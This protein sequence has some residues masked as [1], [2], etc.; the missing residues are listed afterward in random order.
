M[1]EAGATVARAGTTDGAILGELA[2]AAGFGAAA[3]AGA[4]WR[5]CCAE[6]E[7]TPHTIATAHAIN[8]RFNMNRLPRGW[9]ALEA[10]AL[11]PM[12]P[13]TRSHL[14]KTCGLNRIPEINR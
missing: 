1:L 8:D 7:S 5:A 6:I 12:A 4:A 13:R 3:A 14:Q 11:A 10:P 2:R 9:T